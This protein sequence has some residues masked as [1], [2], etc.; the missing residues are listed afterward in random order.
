MPPNAQPLVTVLTPVYNGEKYIVECIESVLAQSYDNWE[1]HIINNCSTDGTLKIAEAYAARDPRIRV[2]TNPQFVLREENHNIAF[3]QVSQNSK[4]CKM[5]HA[6]DWLFSDCIAKMVE[7]AEANP[8]V[9]VVGAYG[10]RKERVVW[11][12]LP[13]PSSFMTGREVCRRVFL[14]G[15]FVFGTPTSVLF[16]SDVVRSRPAFHNVDNEHADAEACFEVLTDRDF[17]F[18]HQV[19][20]YTRVHSEN[21]STFDEVCMW[22]PEIEILLKYGPAYLSADEYKQETEKIWDQYYTFLGSRV[23]RNRAK[24]FWS[25][26]RNT[27]DRLG[28]PLAVRRVAKAIALKVFDLLLNPLTTSTR[29]VGRLT[30]NCSPSR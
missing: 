29:I 20:S 30:A 6:D 12:G 27:L 8:T 23:F 3:R 13:Y 16:A 4:Y 26:H 19:L 2:T 24:G 17:G 10:L 7:L 1:Y 9:A 28:H 11:D 21:A 15:I 18:V 5:V 14:N 22:L 25:Y